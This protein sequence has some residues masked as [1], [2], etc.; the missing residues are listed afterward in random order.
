M[1]WGRLGWV[2]SGLSWVVFWVLS[3]TFVFDISNISS[4]SIGDVVGDNLGT[5]IRKIDTVFTVGGVSVTVFVSSKISFSVVIMDSISVFVYGWSFFVV[6][7]LAISW[8][9]GMVSWGMYYWFVDDWG[10]VW[11]WS[12]GMVSWS[13]HYWLVDYW[14]WVVNWG[15]SVI[16][17]SMYW[18]SMINWS[19]YWSS[20]INWG[21]VVW[22]GFVDWNM[23][24]SMD[25]SAVFFSSIWVMYILRGSMGLA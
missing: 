11:S 12:W 7:S 19:M 15:W 6:W 2:I 3:N 4:V 24:R 16:S 9:W 21:S 13:M 17:W 22:S 1:I 20:M 23:S 25:S 14:G 8:S 18:S 5:A 10:V